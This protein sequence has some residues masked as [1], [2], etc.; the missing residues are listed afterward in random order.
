ML[1]ENLTKQV[2]GCSMRVHSELK[3]GFQ[4]K[5][6]QTALEIELRLNNILF[7]SEREMDIFYRGIKIGKRRVDFL[8][9][10]KIILEIKAVSK[11]E[12]THLAQALNYLECMNLPVGLLIN[13]GAKSLEFKRLYNNKFLEG[14]VKNNIQQASG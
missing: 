3:S 14:Q 6:Y 2:I 8:I 10:N 1:Y 11:L 9:D 7:I 12:D 4:E 5:I 13:F